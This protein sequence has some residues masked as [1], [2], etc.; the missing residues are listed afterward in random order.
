MG[1]A[2]TNQEVSELR[3]LD[4][5]SRPLW[6]G[7]LDRGEPLSDPHMKRWLELGL[8]E[9]VDWSGLRGYVLTTKGTSAIAAQTRS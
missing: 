5:S 6:G 8:I 1:A 3:Y 7:H 9:A 4:K 2:L